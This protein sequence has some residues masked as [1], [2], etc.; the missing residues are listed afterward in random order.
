MQPDSL[1][2]D[3]LAIHPTRTESS[4]IREHLKR[5]P[6]FSGYAS[7]VDA[8]LNIMERCRHWLPEEIGA[9]LSNAALQYN[10]AIYQVIS[11]YGARQLVAQFRNYTGLETA[12]DVQVIAAF[13]LA[14]AIHAL[15][16]LAEHLIIQG[17]EIPALEYYQM[18]LCCIEDY[19]PGASAWLEPDENAACCEIG[20][21]ANAASRHADTKID[22]V[23][24]GIARRREGLESRDQS[25]EAKALELI[26]AGTAM[27]NLN[28][29]LRAWQ[30][31][32]T[33][34]S[35]SKV[36]MGAILKRI[37]WLGYGPP[38]SLSKK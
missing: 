28:S 6:I 37:P 15:C 19:V 21:L 31:R 24:S 29:K 32:E 27:H 2:I 33:G 30:E 14:N 8:V 12:T 25:I 13:A 5:L 3:G 22:G 7:E 16:G 9:E 10:D 20:E 18:H 35:L 26:N 1:S 36:Q 4:T 34:A 11:H 38:S 17:Q 23:L